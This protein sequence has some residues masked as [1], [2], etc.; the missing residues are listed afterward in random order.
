MPGFFYLVDINNSIKPDQQPPN[1][2]IIFSFALIEEAISI[3]EIASS[4]I[5]T[6]R[7][8]LLLLQN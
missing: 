8:P 3:P 4:I 7:T 5:E 2:F 1:S 6:D